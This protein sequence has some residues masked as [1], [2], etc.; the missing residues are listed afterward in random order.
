MFF[1]MFRRNFCFHLQDS[2]ISFRWILSFLWGGRRYINYTGIWKVLANLLTDTLTA[3]F[4]TKKIKERAPF[5]ETSEQKNINHSTVVWVTS[6]VKPHKQVY[7]FSSHGPYKHHVT[8]RCLWS[9]IN[10]PHKF[11]PINSLHPVPK[12]PTVFSTTLTRQTPL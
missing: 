4:I 9:Y 8:A 2:L 1:P 6:I 10:F 3:N 7:N 5:S 11:L 12:P